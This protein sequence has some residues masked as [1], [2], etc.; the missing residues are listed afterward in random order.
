MKN[1]MKKKDFGRLR[2]KRPSVL[3][4]LQHSELPKSR[5]NKKKQERRSKDSESLRKHQDRLQTDPSSPQSTGFLLQ[6]KT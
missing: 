6:K 4:A 2:M 1:K 5:E 3:G